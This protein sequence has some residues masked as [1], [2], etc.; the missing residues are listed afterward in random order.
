MLTLAKMMLDT[1]L[2][3]ESHL[4]LQLSGTDL[5]EI[6]HWHIK[7]TRYLLLKDHFYDSLTCNSENNSPAAIDTWQAL[8]ATI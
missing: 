3:S 1:T 5:K 7:I 2:N 4:V 8:C 6:A